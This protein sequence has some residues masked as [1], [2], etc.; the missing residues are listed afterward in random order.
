VKGAPTS[1]ADLIP[2]SERLRILRLYR[3]LVVALVAALWVLDAPARG[4]PAET[5]AAITA[6]Y[7]LTSLV[8]E[9]LWRALRPPASGL[10]GVLI[11]V[12]GAFLAWAS[13]GTAG[14]GSPV[15][16]L[17]LLQLTTVSLI[18]SW[19]TG[20]KLAI[21]SSLLLL[22]AY[23]AQRA[24]VLA[25]FGNP[26]VRLDGGYREV[27]IR[28]SAYTLIALVTSTFASINE[29]ELRRRRYD[30]EAL[31]K[32][33]RNLVEAQD[34]TS[35]ASVLLAEVADAFG[36]E[37]AAVFALRH[38]QLLALAARGLASGD[39]LV[40][41][42][43]DL[44]GAP[45]V[46]RAL[47]DGRTARIAGSEVGCDAVLRACIKAH[48]AIV[49][50]LHTDRALGV[51]VVEHGLRLGS[52]VERRVLTMLERF[53]SQSALALGNAN[54]LAQIRDQASTDVLTGLANRRALEDG[55]TRAVGLAGREDQTLSVALM[56]IDHF[57]ALN[58]TQGHQFGDQVLQVVGRT[59]SQ[60]TR[61]SDIAARYGGE[62]F[63]ILMPAAGPD[64]AAALT[65][66]LCSEITRRLRAA[67]TLD[68]G[69]LVITMSAGVAS[70]GA[71]GRTP[72]ELVAAADRALYAAKRAGRDR[73]EVA[74]AHELAGTDDGGRI[75][76]DRA[77]SSGAQ[78][79]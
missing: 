21:W 43:L 55:L 57:K 52:R 74:G 40:W 44:S 69:E 62:E 78:E 70:F 33:A 35:V 54:L 76:G 38:G 2:L 17:V 19:R 24:G 49:L 46:T 20:L 72:G 18:A 48:H 23:Y 13:Y 53:C 60:L 41:R 22:S 28:A 1:A 56:D 66:R 11:I 79:A 29:R 25:H 16:Y 7:V 77:G 58:D 63:L 15:G 47:E 26:R 67:V 9:G 36:Y 42:P 37:R 59:L 30:L 68:S 73:V 12:D 34:P 61:A 39:Q 32:L 64:D 10:L 31:A 3:L 4:A 8:I 14:L 65:R 71:H 5:A 75:L 6:V 27:V 51:L 45:H 50:P